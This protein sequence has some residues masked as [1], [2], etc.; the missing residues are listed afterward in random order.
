MVSEYPLKQNKNVL[1]NMTVLLYTYFYISS[2]ILRPTFF[3]IYII[4]LSY[5]LQI[6]AKFGSKLGQKLTTFSNFMSSC[7]NRLEVFNNF[8]SLICSQPRDKQ[9]RARDFFLFKYFLNNQLLTVFMQNTI[10]KLVELL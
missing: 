5:A 1:Q 8:F 9:K 6:S 7:T 3:N 4:Y 2:N 10:S